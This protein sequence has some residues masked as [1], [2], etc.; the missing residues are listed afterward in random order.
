MSSKK[1]GRPATVTNQNKQASAVQGR[2]FI[3][4]SST[5]I[6]NE[7]VRFDSDFLNE[8]E[9]IRHPNSGSQ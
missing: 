6:Q 3:K 5:T 4:S 7:K 2:A 9:L 1:R 8:G